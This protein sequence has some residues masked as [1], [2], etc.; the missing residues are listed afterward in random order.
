MQALD[1]RIV[2]WL[3][4]LDLPLVTP[5]M[6]LAS[7]VG[8]DGIVFV[9]IAFWVALARR[10]IAP[11]VAVLAAVLA[12]QLLSTLMKDVVDR[13]RPSVTYADVHPLVPLPDSSS[14]PSG[15]AWIAG[16]AA[17][18]LWVV[19]PARR[20][21]IVGLAALIALS[22]VYLGRALP[23]RRPR[24]RRRGSRNRTAGAARSSSR[25]C[26]YRPRRRRR[27]T[28]VSRRRGPRR[29]TRR[30]EPC[31]RMTMIS[32]PGF[33]K[34]L[35]TTTSNATRRAPVPPS[36]AGTGRSTLSA[37]RSIAHTARITRASRATSFAPLPESHP[38][39]LA[40]LLTVPPA[41]VALAVAVYQLKNTLISRISAPP[42][43]IQTDRGT[44]AKSK[45]AAGGADC[46][47]CRGLR[48]R[49]RRWR[50]RCWI[51]RRLRLRI[52]G[53]RRW[54]RCCRWTRWARDPVVG[55]VRPGALS[56]RPPSDRYLRYSWNLPFDG[57]SRDS[58]RTERAGPFRQLGIRL[59]VHRRVPSSNRVWVSATVDNPKRASTGNSCGGASRRW[60][61]YTK[62]RLLRPSRRTRW[63][64]MGADGSTRC[65]S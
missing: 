65:G 15:H 36:T 26:A 18:V 64:A 38:L 8:A 53:R 34:N 35:I 2:A 37:N 43:E 42:A 56:P 16:A 33:E 27:S 12:S 22:R 47:A 24:G 62:R 45:L 17:T 55:S 19:I 4:G 5:L 49:G 58:A 50:R 25:S 28:P 14:M 23:Q 29:P 57:R 9:G 20:A 51:R 63:C 10:R 48:R 1:H 44:A 41:S 7:A 11:A 40:L 21:W 6:K 60:L 54:F 13:A 59:W 31:R 52:R 39:P 3:S 46:G 30:S 32:L 61:I